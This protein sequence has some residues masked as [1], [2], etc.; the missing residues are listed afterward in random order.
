MR[1]L[2]RAT[3]CGFGP[4]EDTSDRSG[5][6]KERKAGQQDEECADA[7]PCPPRTGSK[8]LFDLPVAPVAFRAGARECKL[9]FQRLFVA[10]L[11]ALFIFSTI[12]AG[13]VAGQTAGFALMVS[14]SANRSA[15]IPL[16]GANLSGNVFIFTSP[17]T[18]NISRVRFWLDDPSHTGTPRRSEGSAPY[19]F[20]GGTALIALPYSVLTL[21]PGTHSVTAE[22]VLTTGV[23][24]YVT[25]NFTIP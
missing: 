10:S 6:M 19:D 18:S 5:E 8:V 22:I 13:S 16:E 23:S 25:A 12:P 14:A 3:K 9:G 24:E 4:F 1:E 2:R 20:N 7:A 11:S 15:P 21:S 17:D